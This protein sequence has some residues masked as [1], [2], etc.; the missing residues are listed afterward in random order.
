[1]ALVQTKS[2]LKEQQEFSDEEV[3][4][5]SE[6]LGT[7]F[8]ETWSKDNINVTEVFEYLG[9]VFLTNKN[10]NLKS[11][12]EESKTQGPVPTVK[13][14]SSVNKPNKAQNI[15]L[16][17]ASKAQKKKKKKGSWWSLL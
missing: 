9:N 1:M 13:D 6:E 11:H 2:D 16:G 7:E 14:I 4:K 12:P 15:K 3:K 8:F 17:E 5:L 10:N